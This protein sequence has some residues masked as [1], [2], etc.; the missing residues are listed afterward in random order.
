MPRMT[1]TAK[2]AKMA[3]D[4][5]KI[6]EHRARQDRRARAYRL[7]E[8]RGIRQEPLYQ[9]VAEAEA[10]RSELPSD[11]EITRE[12][13]TLSSTLRLHEG[14]CHRHFI[15]TGHAAYRDNVTSNYCVGLDRCEMCAQPLLCGGEPKAHIF[16]DLS[17]AEC[18]ERG[19][20]HGGRCYHVHLCVACGH[21]SAVDSSD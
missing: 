15:E 17:Q 8:G 5:I 19:I 18:R 13:M 16:R 3:A 20:F 7:F 6:A 12:L 14:P 9:L 4:Q 10:G 21:V 2:L 1:K 11:E